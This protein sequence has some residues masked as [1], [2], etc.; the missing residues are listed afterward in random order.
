[1]QC[2]RCKGSGAIKG[3][4]KNAG[5]RNGRTKL[6]EDQVREIRAYKGELTRRELAI[7]YKTSTGNIY[8]ILRGKT[9]HGVEPIDHN[10]IPPID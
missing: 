8:D 4:S 2:P 1:M 10:K 3:N 7:K 6:T 9:W 5:Y